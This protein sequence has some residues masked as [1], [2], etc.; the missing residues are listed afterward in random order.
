[1]KPTKSKPKGQVRRFDKQGYVRL[2][3]TF[4]D[5]P[6]WKK[7]R[8]F[9]EA[10]AWLDLLMEASGIDRRVEFRKK[11]IDLKRGQLV[12]SQRSLAKRWKWTRSNVRTFLDKL[13]GRGTIAVKLIAASPPCSIITLLNYARLNPKK[14]KNEE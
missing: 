3:R 14:G 1:M 5:D 11:P 6:L 8:K 13:Q 7:R 4:R 12:V 9:N 2:W 10:E